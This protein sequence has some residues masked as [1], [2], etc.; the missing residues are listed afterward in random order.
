MLILPRALSLKAKNHFPTASQDLS[1]WKALSSMSHSTRLN[2]T[3][4]SEHVRS[5]GW[6]MTGH[7]VFN[8]PPWPMQA[9]EMIAVGHPY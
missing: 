4:P 1:Q 8:L 7:E 9:P 6:P 5:W 2:E 3:Y